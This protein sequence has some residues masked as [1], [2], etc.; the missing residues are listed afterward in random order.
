[1][2]SIYSDGYTQ[3]LDTYMNNWGLD[4][5]YEMEDNLTDLSKTNEQ[6]IDYLKDIRFSMPL[7][8][9]LRRYICG[10]Y[11]DEIGDNNY[12]YSYKTN[13][14]KV[15]KLSNYQKDD[16]DIMTDEVAEYVEIFM[17]INQ[18]YNSVNGELILDFPKAE[19]RRMFRKE[20]ACVRSKMFL[21][22]FALHMNSA[23]M[24][25]FLTDILAEQTY[26]Y[27]SPDEIIALFCQSNESQNSYSNYLCIKNRYDEIKQIQLQIENA[28]DNYTQFAKAAM[29]QNIKTVDELLAFFQ[30]NNANFNGYSQTAYNEFELLFEKAMKYTKTQSLSN[31]DYIADNTAT[32]IEQRKAKED[33]INNA[34]ELKCISKPEQLAR[35]MLRCIPRYTKKYT[36]MVD[37]QD[38][39]NPDIILGQKEVQIVENDFI[40][41]YNGEK[42]Q[43]SK[44]VRTTTLPKEITMNL[45]MRDRLDS[46]KSNKRP[47]ERKDLVFMKFYVF[48]KYLEEKE[49]YTMNDYQTFIDE[50]NDML[51]RCGMSKLY[52][53]NRFENLILLSLLA[54]N[55]FEMFENIIEYSF[56]NEPQN[57][58]ID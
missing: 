20:G 22:S 26:N 12:P 27:R 21:L 31:D 57:E 56:I 48:S 40:N 58:N 25:K 14:G 43:G 38:K 28:K 10:R 46:L 8:M 36:R 3:R 11:A 1:M 51:L 9:A 17:D 33:R 32:T 29:N 4:K 44:K 47:V 49:D 6:I 54:S 30:S 41:I 45:L 42:G 13:S 2:I 37:I 16:Y 53:A 24:Q 19:A 7:G 18:K 55:P 5:I 34:I 50:C 39:K 23:E 15:I 52:P 35:E